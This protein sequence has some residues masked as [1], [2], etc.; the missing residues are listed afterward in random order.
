MILNVTDSDEG[1]YYCGTEQQWLEDKEFTVPRFIYTYGN[2]T[3]RIIIGE[4]F[5][6]V[7]L[8]YDILR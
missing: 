5:C 2:A 4:C 6:Q 8:L 3:T 1:L 7:F